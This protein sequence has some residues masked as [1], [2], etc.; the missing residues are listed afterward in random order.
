MSVIMSSFR[1]LMAWL[2]LPLVAVFADI[3]RAQ[4]VQLVDVIPAL[5]SN[6]TRN[7]SEPNV[8]VN[9]ANP[10]Q[11]VVSAFTPCPA[12][13]S[14]T[15]APIYFSLD[16]GTTWQ[17]NC[18]VPGNSSTYGTGDI[19]ERFASSGVLY[20]G[21]LRGDSYLELNVLRTSDFTSATPMTILEDRTSEDQPYT[22]AMAVGGDR[23]FV[24]NNQVGA[25]KS[26]AMD[27]S[28]DAAT[29]PPPAGFAATPT[30][31]ETR[32]TCGQDPPPIRPA[33]HNN[34]IIY[35]VYYRQQPTSPCFAG[36][37]LVDVVV[38]RDDN[39]GSGGFTALMDSDGFAGIRVV[40][41]VSVVWAGS[42]GNERLQGSQLSIAVDPS[43]SSNV[44]VAWADGDSAHYTLHVRHSTTSGATWGPDI[45]TITPGDNPALAIN[46]LG[47]LGFLYQKY[48]NPGTCGGAGGGA[49]WETHFETYDGTTW[50]DLPHPLA[51]V[52][53]NAGSFPLG[54]YEHVLAIGQDFYGVFAANNYPDTNNFYPGV[55]YQRYVNFGTHQLFAD[56]TLTTTA[57]PSF[58]PFFFHITNLPAT[59][60]FYVRDWTTSPSS[61]DN[62]EE[63]SNGPDWWTMSD[64]WNRLTNINGGFNTN[65]QPNQQNAQDATTGHN[66]AFV[67]VHRNAA[68]MTGP[69]VNVTARFVYADYGLGVAYQDVSASSSA[70]LT[71]SATDTVKTLADG[72]GVQWDVPATRSTHVCMAVEILAPGDPYIPELVGRAPGWPTTDWTIP[73]DNNKAQINMDLPAMG[74]GAGTASFHAIAH[75]AALFT[76]DMVIRYSVPPKILRM[77]EGAQ[78]GVV[79]GETQPL[80]ESGTLTLTNM[81][82]AENRWIE[83]SYSAPNV[84]PG[85]PI[86]VA[87]E[88]MNGNQAVNGFTIAAQPA[89]GETIIRENLKLHRAAFARLYAAFQIPQ[90]AQEAKAAGTLLASNS[91]TTADYLSFLNQHLAAITTIVSGLLHSQKST[92]TF[93][94]I[95]AVKVLQ[96]AVS[97]QRLDLA[98]NAHSSF[99]NKLDA[100]ETMLQKAEGD[101]ADILQMV[102][103]QQHLYS[104]APRLTPLKA[105]RHVVEESDEF[106]RAYGKAH[107]RGDSYAKM[108]REL[109]DSFHDTAEALECLDK[110]LEKDAEEIQRHLDS[111]DKLEKAHRSYL[112]ELQNLV[113]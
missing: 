71:F 25:S 16:G 107:A 47:T 83:V 20:A 29:A 54:D 84:K 27:F 88:E 113:K 51:N 46:K 70:T 42:M 17:L 110:Q 80:G 63:P 55:Q 19:T 45:K 49:C 50:T 108:L 52:P 5:Y 97:S 87:L 31:L 93:A 66:Y 92:D 10:D 59:A 85:Q 3:A 79:G 12:T 34:G 43:D 82:P 7:D 99:L 2:V 37:N 53:D 4:Q 106:I 18:I 24:G 98:A 13:I 28:Q 78:I 23:V 75:N 65:D 35:A 89:S 103:W 62:G 11:I 26:T 102:L 1:N 105:A 101:P 112:L 9:P 38:A 33:I 22:Q 68:P 67:R 8:T 109:R 30:T 64:V 15:Q 111:P 48:V 94:A 6:E 104:T 73:A 69:D 81:Q 72:A 91:I 100:F 40:Q 76:R 32:P 14:T 95:Q 60:D 96:G 39:W 90:S 57:T 36:S 41:S 77:L 44:Y 74:A 21:I 58:D 61:H 86:P 56:S